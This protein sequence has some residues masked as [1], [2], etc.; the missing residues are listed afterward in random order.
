M[1]RASAALLSFAVLFTTALSA[2]FVPP[3][4]TDYLFL[5]TASDA[6]SIWINP[7]GPATTPTS[8]IM[9][10]LA[11]SEQ[12]TS[13]VR[14]AQWTVGF[15]SR[16]ISVAYQR[17][18]L[19]DGENNQAFRLGAALPFRD[20]AVGAAFT[21]YNTEITQRGLDLGFRYYPLPRI[22]LGVV[23]LNVGRP[24]VRSVELPVTFG[25][26]GGW[27]ILPPMLQV[28]G[29]VRIN[30]RLI[31]SGYD[32]SYRIGAEFVTRTRL[33]VGAVA[34]FDLGG[35]LSVDRWAVGLSVGGPYRVVAVTSGARSDGVER[36]SLTGLA[37]RQLSQR[38]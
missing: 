3:R 22:E 33:P 12:E 36:V 16:G 7:A 19:P 10:E 38:R 30:E 28:A 29:E 32:A 15:T 14:L 4:S 5:A 8:S 26:G 25:V 31:E 35:D 34:T 13:D 6:R 37:I 27:L 18:R 1:L 9:A 24:I 23:L 17:D 21:F 11:F 2:Q 20:G